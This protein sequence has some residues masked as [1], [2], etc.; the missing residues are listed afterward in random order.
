VLNGRTQ[1]IVNPFGNNVGYYDLLVGQTQQVLANYTVS[2]PVTSTI[3]Y[4][5]NV[6]I[7]LQG[8]AQIGGTGRDSLAGTALADSLQGGTGA[9]NELVGG[10]GDDTYTSRAAGDSIIEFAGG[11]IDTVRTDLSVFV[12]PAN[13]E[14]L[15]QI[16]A[17]A[18]FVGIGNAEDNIIQGFAMNFSG[19]VLAGLGGN[20][21]LTMASF[22]TAAELVGGTGDDTYIFSTPGTSVVEY[23]NEGIDTIRTGIATYTLPTHVENLTYIG[24]GRFDGVGNASDNIITGGTAAGELVGLGGNDTYVVRNVGDSIVEAAGGGTDTVQTALSFYRLNAANVENLTYTGL[25]SFTGIGNA[26]NNVITGGA[27][28]DFLFAGAG[29]DTLVGG[30][31]ADLFF[32]DTA[33]NGIDAISD[34]TSGSDRMAF[35]Q[36]VFTHTPTFALVQGAGAQVATTTN[37]TF[38]FNSTTGVLSFDADGTGAG[39]A[40]D[41]VTLSPGLTMTTA[42]FVFYG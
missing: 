5:A 42:D 23:A 8:W 19:S 25:G 10:A 22:G 36:S 31:G 28:A 29:T 18:S 38:L 11:G 9:A 14:N 20:D 34:F 39:A 24:T 1:F 7:T 33:V 35:N 16:G 12:L 37:S 40:I 41:I 32:F 27:R 17:P 21:T 4:T 6:V 26:G 2:N 3:D 13:V 15:F 30:A